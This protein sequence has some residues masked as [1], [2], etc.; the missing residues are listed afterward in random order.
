MP[1]PDLAMTLPRY[2]AGASSPSTVVARVVDGDTGHAL[3]ALSRA[4][5]IRSARARRRA[6]V[7]RLTELTDDRRSTASRTRTAA[8]ED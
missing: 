2:A 3:A 8:E 1:N 4:D 7:T 5:A 6:A